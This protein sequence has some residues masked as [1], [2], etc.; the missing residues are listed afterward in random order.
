MGYG[1]EFL[2]HTLRVQDSQEKILR[3]E[4]RLG[5]SFSFISHASL[6]LT[7]SLDYSQSLR[8]PRTREEAQQ[9]AKVEFTN[10]QDQKSPNAAWPWSL[11][12]GDNC[13]NFGAPYSNKGSFR[14][15]GYVM[16]DKKRLDAMEILEKE[17][18]SFRAHGPL[19]SHGVMLTDLPYFEESD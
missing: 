6:F 4:A 7:K 12:F 13:F 15:W 19:I 2:A 11:Q 18:V 5:P 1:L 9:L 17:A 14:S 3:I 16:W 8:Q 10:D